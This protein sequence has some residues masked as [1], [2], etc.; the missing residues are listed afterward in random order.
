MFVVNVPVACVTNALAAY[1]V[2]ESR[3]PV[4]R[5]V[6]LG[7]LL[8]R[9]VSISA[10]VLAIIE[11]PSWHWRSTGVLGLIVVAVLTFIC[12][13]NFELDRR[14]PML[15]VCLFRRGSFSAALAAIATSFLGLFEFV[16]LVTQYFPLVHG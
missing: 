2:P 3:S 1:A 15:D 4:H 8:L 9:S 14:D 16:F 5:R 11:G 7:G 6:D 12:F 10:L 13:A